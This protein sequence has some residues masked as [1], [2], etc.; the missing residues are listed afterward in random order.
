[1][2]PKPVH[3][4]IRFRRYVD[5]RGPTPSHM[6]HLGRCWVWTG[7]RDHDG[8]GFFGGFGSRTIRAHRFSWMQ[9]NGVVTRL[10]I[11]HRCDN[12]SCVRP[13]HLFAGTLA[14]NNRDMARKGRA[15]GYR[16]KL[17]ARDAVAIRADPRYQWQ[18]AEDYGVAQTMVGMIK[19]RVKWRNAEKELGL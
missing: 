18:I 12:P 9:A 15:K 2:P 8:Y 17:T 14:D 1:M 11:C 4:D 19:R 3:P 5:R 6:P 7:A 16:P 10:A 13:S